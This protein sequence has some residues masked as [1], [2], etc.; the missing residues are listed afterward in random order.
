MAYKNYN[1]KSEFDQKM[2][3]IRRVA[4]VTAGGKRFSFRVTVVAGNRKGDVGVGM[5]KAGDTASAIDKAFRNAKK[6]FIKVKTT[7][8]LSIPHKTMAK[9]S[10]SRIAIMPALKGRGLIA[11]SSV[12]TVLGLAGVKNASSKIFSRSKNK[13]NIAMATIKA[14]KLLK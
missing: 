2:I 1:Q 5:G 8:D 6:N 3:D 4:R 10:S 11:G 14:L 13:V 7:K 12:R 9:F